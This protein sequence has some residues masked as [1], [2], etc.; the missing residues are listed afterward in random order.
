MITL[1]LRS[2][3]QTQILDYFEV[4]KKIEKKDFKTIKLNSS[5]KATFRLNCCYVIV[6]YVKMRK[7]SCLS[8]YCKNH[9][10]TLTPSDLLTITLITLFT[11]NMGEELLVDVLKVLH[12]LIHNYKLY[13]TERLT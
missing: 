13:I 11:K 5:R 6:N 3:Y 7:N 8:P 9:P 2:L 1:F 12:K 4:P 10:G